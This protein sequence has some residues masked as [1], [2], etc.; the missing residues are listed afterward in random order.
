MVVDPERALRIAMGGEPG[1]DKVL[2]TTIYAEVCNALEKRGDVETCRQIA[3]SSQNRELSEYAQALKLR[4]VIA[5]VEAMKAVV[6][7]RRD[8]FEKTLPKG[9][10]VSDAIQREAASLRVALDSLSRYVRYLIESEQDIK[11]RITI[12][13]I[14]SGQGADELKIIRPMWVMR[15]A[16]THIWL[17]NRDQPKDQNSLDVDF[18]LV[19]K[20]FDMV[21]SGGENSDYRNW[22]E[23]D[24]RQYMGGAPL[25]FQ[26]LKTFKSQ[27]LQTVAEMVPRI[28][29]EATGGRLGGDL[30]ESI[31][32]LAMETVEK[33]KATFASI[34]LR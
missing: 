11:R 32:A 30:F 31:M 20:A 29:F 19:R 2:A 13:Q 28:A 3:N 17:L 9:V 5:P 7:S 10:S 26:E 34:R 4:D 18:A 16:L 12:L 15:Y 21:L 1:A 33:D 25:E 23:S 24:A 14:K 8:A 6:K 22:L 27:A